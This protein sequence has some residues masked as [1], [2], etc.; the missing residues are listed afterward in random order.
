MSQKL[1]STLSLLA[2]GVIASLSA[3][4][5]PL[6]QFSASPVSGCA[7]LVV[8]FQDQS[9]GNP[10]Q[11]KWDLGNA[12]ISFLQHPVA[13]YFNPGTYAVKLVVQ[14]AAGKDSLTRLQYITVYAS[15]TVDFSSSF[16]SGCAPLTVQFANN[17]TAGSG[18]IASVLWDL[19]DGS[20]SSATSPSHTYA[21]PGDY[22]V[23][24]QVTNSMGCIK[25]LTKNN[26]IHVAPMVNAAFT[27]SSPTGCVAPETIFFQNQSTGAGPLG[28]SWSFGDGGTSTVANPSHT[29]NTAG[30]YNVQLV[31]ISAGGCRD[32]IVF[33]NLNIASVAAN[34]SVPARACAGAPILFTNTSN[35]T[36][37]SVR[38]SFGA[39]GFS[40]EMNPTWS[41]ALGGNYTIKLVGFFGACKD[42]VSK[43]ITVSARPATSFTGSPLSAC[44]AP[45][46]VNFTSTTTGA[47]SYSWSF[48]DGDSSVSASPAHTYNSTGTYTVRLISTNAAGCSDT[49]IR[50]NY[51]SIEKPQ[52]NINQLP[53]QG[54][55]PFSWTF[56]TSIN[57]VDPVVSYAWNFGDG[58]TSTL[59]NPTHVFAAGLYDI[60]LITTTAGGC[61]DTVIKVGGIRASSK[62]QA[63]FSATPRVVCAFN[64]VQFTNQSTGN[65]TGWLWL[66]GDG[67]TSTES[68]PGHAYEDTGFFIVTLI[69]DNYGCYDTLVMPDYIYVNPPIARFNVLLDCNAAYVRNFQDT[70]I[71]ADEWFWDFG[72]GATSTQKNPVHT[73]STVGNFTVTLRVKNNAT[74]CGHS[75]THLVVI[76]DEQANFSADL[77]EICK[78]SSV[79]FTAVQNHPGGIA[80]YEWNFGDGNVGTGQGPQHLYTQAGLFLVSLLI[81]DA[82]GCKDTLTLPAY[83]RVNGPTAD[84][85]AAVPGSCLSTAISFNDGSVTDGTHGITQWKW[86]YGDGVTELLNAPPFSHSYSAAGTYSVSLTVTDAAGCKDSILKNNI[87]VISRPVADFATDDTASCPGRPIQFTNAST[88]PALSYAWNFGNGNSSTTAAPAHSYSADGVYTI[89]LRITDEYGCTD[90]S[91]RT[92]YVRIATPIAAFTMSDSISTCPP[93]IVQFTNHSTN[94]S[95]YSWDF[96]DGNFSSTANPSHFYNVAGTYFPR[97]TITG[98]GGCT[99]VLVKRVQVKGPSGSFSYQNFKG[100]KPLTVRFAATSISRSSFTW[101]F[102]DGTTIT[103]NDSI[104][105]HTYTVPGIYVPK[106][107]LRDVAGCTV[108]ITGQDTIVVNGVTASFTADTLLLCSNGTVQFTNSTVSNDIITS[109]AWDFGDGS[110]SSLASPA[111]FYTTQGLYRVKL[112]A[113]TA[114]GCIDSS[115]AVNPVKVVLT[116]S[117]SITQSPDGCVPLTK[118]FTGNLLNADSSVINWRWLTGNGD[119]SLSQTTNAMSFPNAGNYSIQ[120]TA[121]NSSGCKD[122]VRAG[123]NA[124]A[125]PLVN[126]GAD[127]TICRGTATTLR[128][129]GAANYTW[130]PAAGLSCTQC[131]SPGANPLLETNYIVTGTSQQGCENKDTIKI[132]LQYPLRLQYSRG[133]TLCLGET[134]TLSASGAASY[135]WSPSA[136]LNNSTTAS[137]KASPAI[138]TSYMVVGTDAPG[139]FKDTAYFQV[140]VYPIPAIEA[141]PDVTIN[142]GQVITL[143]PTISADVTEV[144]WSPTGGIFRSQFPSIDLKPK[145]TTKYLVEARNAGGCTATDMLTVNVLCNGANVFIPNTFSPNG[146]GANEVFFPR[147]TGLFAIKTARIFNRWGEQVFESYNMKPNDALGGWNGTYKG[148]QLPGDVFVYVFEIV[149]DNNAILLYKGDVALIR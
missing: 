35:P 123:F 30:I 27:H 63:L 56:G 8:S 46:T 50:T 96:G 72:D 55:A 148:K 45:L 109:Y 25:T 140:K 32:T 102:N 136:G 75:T 90:E 69:I 108:P 118:T 70:S 83:I 98:P 19:G 33:R 79:Q 133:D 142:V 130:S 9:T 139:C 44:S 31:A 144:N 5:Q 87:L 13:T 93:L 36:P 107:I 116:P 74:G 126:A 81:T 59:A 97:L 24:L 28:F 77:T 137:V 115:T 76:A 7:P 73:Y 26:Y 12:T 82:A 54:C 40:S 88:G 132:S 110:T 67:S 120:L 92:Q 101:D 114:M 80:S 1:K 128:A 89:R 23:S 52:I 124:W 2:L 119:S 61:R 146:D 6:A 135:V 121:T 91:I 94:Q 122:T 95:S 22:N 18:S 10:T 34:F 112:K 3:I 39:G 99:A 43:M 143:T 51:V 129:T 100:C 14:S 16:V 57:S 134:A 4:A 125:L 11:W 42:S 65:V 138:T 15:P 49:L 149:C 103:T 41:Y 127:V 20:F 106:M 104:I 85:N 53:Q 131:A 113:I 58:T 48:G 141:G 38:W 117:V 60:Q 62:P 71:G 68:N 84:F 111:H 21:A 64:T 78:G 37:D 147:G 29:Y 105:S 47:V 86:S 145:E 17:S 66:F